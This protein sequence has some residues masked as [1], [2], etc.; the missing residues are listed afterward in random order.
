MGVGY[1]AT[2]ET[3]GGRT[4]PQA[5]RIT[6]SEPA[7]HSVDLI[8]KGRYVG[9]AEQTADDFDFTE[10]FGELDEE[11]TVLNTEAHQLEERIAENVTRILKD[12]V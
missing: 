4:V 2:T 8:S 7:T 5:C 3:W 9:V 6:H 11:L 10:R 12:T 1:D